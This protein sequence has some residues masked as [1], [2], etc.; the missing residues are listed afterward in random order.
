M[1]SRRLLSGFRIDC[2][3]SVPFTG[4]PMMPEGIGIGQFPGRAPF[5]VTHAGALPCTRIERWGTV[6]PDLG[7]GPKSVEM[8]LDAAEKSLCATWSVENAGADGAGNFVQAALHQ[9]RLGDIDRVQ[10]DHHISNARI[11]LQILARDVDALFGEHPVDRGQDAWLIAVYVEKAV[12]PLLLYLIS[13]P[14][15]SMPIFC[16]A[17]SVLPPICGVSS[18]LSMPCKGE[19]NAS[20]AVLGSSGNTSNAAPASRLERS[21]PTS[22]SIS[23]TVPREALIRHAPAGISASSSAPIMRWVDAV[24]GT[25]KVTTSAVSSSVFS[26]PAGRALPSASLFSTSWYTTRIPRLSASSPTCVPMRP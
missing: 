24:S 2:R 17:S 13:F 21:T 12:D 19:M 20:P 18:T 8:S 15:T 16:C 5:P 26:D 4:P 14:A 1:E 11:C 25:C 3:S 9:A 23:T 7:C 6:P 22:A 10:I